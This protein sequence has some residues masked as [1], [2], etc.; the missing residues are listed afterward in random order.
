MK[1]SDGHRDFDAAGAPKLLRI[2]VLFAVLAI[3]VSPIASLL[4][5][6]GLIPDPLLPVLVIVTMTVLL[7][8]ASWLG[9]SWQPAQMVI[10][11]DMLVFRRGRRPVVKFPWSEIESV[12]L[13]TRA[14]LPGWSWAP[15]T[16]IWGWKPHSPLVAVRTKKFLGRRVLRLLRIRA[17]G[18]PVT[19]VTFFE[20]GNPAEFVEAVRPFFSRRDL[21]E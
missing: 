1:L 16:W 13:T 18:V 8:I 21:G 10:Q 19:S 7:P 15:I 9:K 4:S 14:G 12:E 20:V 6:G 3:G 17:K 11:S 5:G 2:W